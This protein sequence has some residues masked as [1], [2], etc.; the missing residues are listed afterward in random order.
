MTTAIAALVIVVASSCLPPIEAEGSVDVQYVPETTTVPSTTVP[1]T[2]VPSTTVPSTTTTST[3]TTSTTTTST[4]TTL[5][6][7][8]PRPPQPADPGVAL[9]GVRRIIDGDTI[10]LLNGD[11]VRL[12][13][14]DA[15]ERDE[16]GARE[17]TEFLVALI[18]NAPVAL[19]PGARSDTDRYGRLLRY[20]EVDGIDTN[21]EMI[22]NGHA[23]ARYDGLDGY[24]R[25]PRQDLY[26][27]TD[28]V[29][30]P[31]VSCLSGISGFA[32]VPPAAEGTDPRFGTCRE[33]IAN[34]Y[35][36]YV[37]DVDIEYHWYR[38]ADADGRVCE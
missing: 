18:G 28:A 5:A 29:S 33:A 23:I 21:Y 31:A 11:R 9:L 3:T 20:V 36:P 12:I 32:A 30:E 13:G 7:A 2:T 22:A 27:R 17:A 14:I 16:C 10:E 35:G 34:G 26:R 6:V 8:L 38:D 4:T 15:P 24:G 1:S 19:I 37:R 25:H